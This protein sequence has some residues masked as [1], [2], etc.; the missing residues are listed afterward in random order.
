MTITKRLILSFGFSIIVAFIIGLVGFKSISSNTVMTNRLVNR[1]VQFLSNAHELKIEALQHRRYE[2][3]FFLNIGKPEKQAKYIKKFDSVSKVLKNR[4]QTMDAA[5]RMQLKLPAEVNQSIAEA[6]TAY[7]TYYTSFIQLTRTVLSDDTI[8]PQQ[9]NKLMVP[10]KDHIYTFEKNIDVIVD[11]GVAHLAAMVDDASRAGRRLTVIILSILVAGALLI[12]VIA[13]LTV[14]RIRTGLT[15]VSRQLQDISCGEGDLTLRIDVKAEDEIGRL[16]T[17]F[18]SFLDTLQ[19]MIRRISENAKVLGT[20]STQLSALSSQ[21]S[22]GATQASEKTQIVAAST[23]EVN[24]NT[25]NIASAMEEATTNVSMIAAASEQMGATVN[26]IAQN[27]EKARAATVNAVNQSQEAATSINELSGFSE[28]IGKVTEVITEISEQT[29]LLALNATIEAARAGEAGK[30]FAVVANEIKELAQQT[31]GATQNIKQQIENIQNSTQSG[32]QA[33]GQVS[34]VVGNVD[35][36]VSTV[37]TAVEEQS[38]TTREITANVAEASAGLQE[39]NQN[40]AQSATVINDVSKE[41]SE[42]DVSTSEIAEGTLHLDT[43]AAEL[44]RLSNDLNE[45]VGRFKI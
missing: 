10:F 14:V 29:N 12:A 38:V 31:A 21:L 45:M 42:M 8:T 20:A 16:S 9:A 5:A 18:N 15:V 3:D 26:E 13:Y 7:N 39:I 28:K 35:E 30:G 2:K 19:H 17:L 11:A 1:D 24:A 37:A 41:I 40:L 32:V 44:S 34:R 6:Q 4:L 27:S 36:I 33:I 25:N 43:S 22:D 23:E